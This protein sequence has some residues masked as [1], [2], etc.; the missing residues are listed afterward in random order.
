[1]LGGLAGAPQPPVTGLEPTKP[2]EGMS[3]TNPPLDAAELAQVDAIAAE[4]RISREE[5]ILLLVGLGRTA[6]DVEPGAPKGPK[7]PDDRH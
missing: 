7:A 3:V 4:R 6:N 2:S 1:L 5:A